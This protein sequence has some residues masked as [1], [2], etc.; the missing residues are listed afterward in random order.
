[1]HGREILE[2][3]VKKHPDSFPSVALLKNF[4]H[5]SA[6]HDAVGG[7]WHHGWGSYLFNGQS[8]AYQADTLRKQEALYKAAMGVK[9]ALEIGVYLGHSLL[10]MLIA[11]PE[12]KITC[13]DCEEQFS[14]PAVAYLN[15]HFGDRIT[16]ICG[17]AVKV[18]NTLP[19]D[20]FD[21][22]HI[23]ADHV[24]AAVH[25]QT[26]ASLR[27][28]KEGAT[29]VY[30][31]YEA[32]RRVIDGFVEQGYLEKPY[33]P[34]C[35]WT[36]CVT[37]LVGKTAIGRTVEI[38]RRYSALSVERLRN[39][40][41]I[42][43][44]V[45]ANG[46]EGDIVEAG[47]YKGGSML[48]MMRAH[49]GTAAGDS[50]TPKRRFHLYDTFTGMTAPTEADCDFTGKHATQLIKEHENV[51]CICDLETV[52]KTIRAHTKIPEA[53]IEYHVGDILQLKEFPEKI[54]VL[55]LD[56]DWYESTAFELAHFYDRVSSGGAVIIDDYGHWKG[57]RKAVD[58][59]LATHP[60]IEL[61][62]ID[63]T[64]VF[65]LKP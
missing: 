34:W 9:N 32:V 12:L 14:G 10:I 35:L 53:H 41:E 29:V 40:I 44:Y 61:R 50:S 42:V 64:G 38:C 46:I 37:K 20:S 8:Y 45:N 1:M 59:F 13:V 16:F 21:L 55:R 54:A 47:I 22:I 30:D 19:A 43:Q 39:N 2:A 36:N 48:A 26:L 23:D 49:E 24:D 28:A 57:S 6:L 56:T 52:Q 62:K 11:N 4:E 25:A 3:I 7:R 65:F 18:V 60:G 31:D 58:E 27:V 5:F 17:D 51:L 63:Y 33:V 15:K